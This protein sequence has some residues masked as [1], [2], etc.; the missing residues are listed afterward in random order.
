MEGVCH[1]KTKTFRTADLLVLQSLKFYIPPLEP[2][3]QH[4]GSV[5]QGRLESSLDY[6]INNQPGKDR[7]RRREK[8]V[9]LI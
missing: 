4:F 3:S 7:Q 6:H 8:R 5:S 2:D 9:K 1:N